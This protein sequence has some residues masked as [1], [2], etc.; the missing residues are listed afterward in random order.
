MP[1]KLPNSVPADGPEPQGTEPE[2]TAPPGTAPARPRTLAS[3]ALPPM[4]L[5]TDARPPRPPAAPAPPQP[6][7]LPLTA[8]RPSLLADGSDTEFRGLV[9][10]MLA[11]ASA[12]VEVRNRLGGLIGLSGTQYTILSSITRLSREAPELGVNQLAEHLHLS[13]AFVTIE[14]NK[15]VAAGLVEKTTNPD[16]RRRVVLAATPEAERLLAELILVQ[17]PANDTLFEPLTAKEFKSLRAIIAK[18]SRTGEAT[19]RIIEALAP[20]GTLDS[21][22]RTAAGPRG[23]DGRTRPGN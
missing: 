9:H 11:F 21:A 13:G 5:P 19:L 18:L 17:C 7:G 2:S 22:K 16:D 1:P 15:L 12:I 8:S 23:V 14:V 20:D 10:D 3:A 6:P 4:P